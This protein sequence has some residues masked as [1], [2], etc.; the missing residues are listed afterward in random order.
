[1]G[2]ALAEASLDCPPGTQPAE[3]TLAEGTEA[4]CALPDGTR[5]GPSIKTAATGRITE[6]G[7][8]EDGQ[9]HGKWR[10][11]DTQGRIIRTGQM[12]DGAPTGAW[13]HFT[14][15]NTPSATITHGRFPEPI[16]AAPQ[17]TDPR[18]RW[19][20]DLGSAATAW[21]PIAPDSVG[22]AIGT[23]RLVVV[24]VETGAIEADIPLPAP[25]RPDLQVIDGRILG[26]TGPGELFVAEVEA[27]GG[28]RWQRVRTP[29]GVTHAVAIDGENGVV[30]REGSGRLAGIDR[31]TGDTLWAGQLFMDKVPPLATDRLAIGVRNGREVRAVTIGDGAFAW[32]ARMPA[33]ILAIGEASDRILVSLKGGMV[34]ALDRDT[35]A[36][37]WDLSVSLTA[38]VQPSWAY[39]GA[40]TWLSTPLEAWRID[41]V[42]GV[43]L[44]HQTARPPPE[45]AA[46]DLSVGPQHTCTTG[47]K[48]GLRCTPGDWVLPTGAPVLPPLVHNATV[49]LAEPTGR[50][51]AV[52][53]ALTTAIDSGTLVDAELLVDEAIDVVMEWQGERVEQSVPWV[54]VERVRPLED[55][56]VTSAAIQ[57]PVPAEIWPADPME[58]V[59]AAP[60]PAS[61]RATLWLDDFVLYDDLGEGPFSVHPDW[62]AEPAGTTWRMS[63]WHRHQP[64]LT[65]LTVT[66]GDTTEPAE[67]DALVQC[68]APPAQ[69]SGEALL[70]N[71]VRSWRIAGRLE[72]TPHPHSLDGEP[73]CLL[74]IALSGSDQGAWSSPL[75][76]AWS[77]IVVEAFREDDIDYSLDPDIVT[78]PSQLS[79]RV[80]LDAYEPAA[81]ARTAVTVDGVVDLRIDESPLFGSV[82]RAF[83]GPELL[84]EVPV[85]ELTY[86]QVAPDADGRVL[87]TPLVDEHV[88]LARTVAHDTP[89]DSWR[90][91][92]TRSSCESDLEAQLAPDEAP[93]DPES[94]PEADAPPPP[95]TAMPKPLPPARSRWR[96]NRPQKTPK[97]TPT[98]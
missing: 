35:G 2:P 49:L 76:P 16:H 6:R 50:I 29:M 73:G 25:L 79:G 96:R 46:A 27:G 81:S 32:Q 95:P 30:V 37:L 10:Y 42:R 72:I 9:Q 17:P 93:S 39:F 64:T 63:W 34:Q 19:Q 8:W 4:W 67:V 5:Q 24:S 82:L 66:L 58:P 74:D 38:K 13:T 59:G 56:T 61:L 62:D 48:G 65:A 70:E 26:V 71:G 80:H 33:S 43:V 54:V 53:P 23:D 92:W 78:L 47:R 44:D 18:Y 86:G 36:P 1:M 89:T 52:D 20:L 41:P 57:L 60:A 14:E 85:P 69:F 3:H 11:Y 83:A 68:A 75:L 91:L 84:L 88:H 7:Y 97:G 21:W 55:C 15:T 90:L 98:K 22:I 31:T 94:A 51:L 28:G 40:D 87:P 77:E 45:Q 12:T